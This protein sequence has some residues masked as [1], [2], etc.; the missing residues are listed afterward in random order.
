MKQ[1]ALGLF[2]INQHDFKL[3]CGLMKERKNP[4]FLFPGFDI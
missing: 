4:T 2:E 1:I 3:I